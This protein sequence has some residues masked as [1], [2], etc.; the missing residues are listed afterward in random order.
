M[1]RRNF[2]KNTSLISGSLMTLYSGF[3]NVTYGINKYNLNYA[4]HFG[5]FK[6]IAGNDLIDQLKFMHDQGF[7]A[8]E[9]NGMKGKKI[10]LQNKISSFLVKNNMQMGVFV[11]HKIHWNKPN[12]A[13]GDPN[14][15]K[16]FL[17]EIKESVEVAKRV[18]ARW[19][20]VVPGHLDLRLN[21]D[22]QTQNVIKA[23]RLAADIL[24]PHNLIMVIEPLNFRDHPGLFLSKSPQAFQICKAVNSPSCKILFDIYHQQIEEGNLIPNIKKCWEEIAYFQIGDNPG[25]NEPTTGE[26]NYKNIFKYI[27]DRG[28]KGILGM[29]HGNSKPNKE[30]EYSVINAYKKVDNF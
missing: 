17:K 26:I 6:N 13:S 8:I 19:M 5:M 15:R 20:T 22:Y 30:G 18:N 16:E 3:S 21:I 4:P 7:M 1:K 2:I 24:E 12:L 28:Y 9:D 27:H 29:E 10:E 23:L 14:T 11:A 25:R